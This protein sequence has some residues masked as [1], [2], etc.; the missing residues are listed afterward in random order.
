V[1]VCV[2]V[3]EGV[4]G[5]WGCECARVRVGGKKVHTVRVFLSDLNAGAAVGLSDASQRHLRVYVCVC[6]CGCVCV[7][8]CVCVCVYV[9]VRVGGCVISFTSPNGANNKTSHTCL[10]G[11]Q[12]VS[13]APQREPACRTEVVPSCH[14][15]RRVSEKE[16]VRKIG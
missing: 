15:R 1:C 16:W 6:V 8:V 10:V 7:V 5:V 12:K 14:Q 3:I 2:C 4:W 9:C 11:A 13:R